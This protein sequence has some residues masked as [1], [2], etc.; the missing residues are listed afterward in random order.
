MKKLLLLLFF[1]LQLNLIQAQNWEWETRPH[2]YSELDVIFPVTKDKWLIAGR[3]IGSGF[4]NAN[5]PN[6]IEAYLAI[7]DSTGTIWGTVKNSFL[8][9]LD[10]QVFNDSI[11]WFAYGE[12]D[13]DKIK[14]VVIAKITDEKL[15]FQTYPYPFSSQNLNEGID[16]SVSPFLQ[17]SIAYPDSNGFQIKS[18]TPNRL[19]TFQN[20]KL[21]D[22]HN[23]GQENYYITGSIESDGQDFGIVKMKAATIGSYTIEKEALENRVMEKMLFTNNGNI[24]TVDSSSIFYLT[25]N[26]EIISELNFSSTDSYEDIMI[27]DESI[28]L[29]TKNESNQFQIQE[30]NF[31]FDLLNAHVLKIPNGI[32]STKFYIK[33]G[34]IGIGTTIRTHDNDINPTPSSLFLKV[35]NKDE[36]PQL[37]GTDVAIEKIRIPQF[38]TW[39]DTICEDELIHVFLENIKLTIKNNGPK[40]VN[41]LYLNFKFQNNPLDLI[42]CNG[43]TFQFIQL[44]NRQFSE[45]YFNLNIV[46]GESKVITINDLEVFRIS[47]EQFENLDLLPICFSVSSIDHSL[48]INPSNNYLCENILLQHESITPTVNK[49]NPFILFPNPTHDRIRVRILHEENTFSNIWIS[50]T[51]GQQVSSPIDFENQLL[52]EFN[53]KNLPNGI[54]FINFDD[55]ENLYSEKFIKH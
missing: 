22:F 24:V 14:S 36:N 50:N 13:S 18:V 43:T 45:K 16:F 41:E 30:F 51:L 25:E 54:Y 29:V 5:N 9:I 6:G 48:D 52:I 47:P 11:L 19:Y 53:L 23:L 35:F 3:T 20:S 1:F 37:N 26:L 40:T 2:V 10:V 21:T 38:T 7:I 49:E 34:V 46:P 27:E 33:N 31:D 15:D 12:M 39:K 17:T 32:N 42:S 4:S 8:H 55:G 28:F 44:I